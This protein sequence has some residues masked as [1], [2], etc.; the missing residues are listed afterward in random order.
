M[1]ISKIIVSLQSNMHHGGTS[2]ANVGVILKHGGSFADVE[3]VDIRHRKMVGVID[4][5]AWSFGNI[6]FAGIAYLVRSWRLLAFSVT[7]PL[8]VPIFTWR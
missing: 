2:M 1:T 8:L 7:A 6:S 4:S 3:W 5:L